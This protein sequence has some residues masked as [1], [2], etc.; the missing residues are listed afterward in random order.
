MNAA[1]E[2]AVAL[3]LLAATRQAP[4]R[5]ADDQ[6]RPAEADGK[7]SQ[8]AEIGVTLLVHGI[9][10]IPGM[11]GHVWGSPLVDGAVDPKAGLDP[12]E[13]LPSSWTGL[14]GYLERRAHRF[15]GVIR[16]LGSALDLPAC[17]DT[18]ATQGDPESATVFELEFSDGAE[19]DGLAYRAL[20]L[21][22]AVR[23]LCEFRN[24]QRV[25]LVTHSAGGLAAR[26]Y[27]QS[28]LPGLPFEHNVSRLI[29][30]STPHMGVVSA[31]TLGEMLGT[32]ATSLSV[33]ADLIRRMNQSLELPA[34]VEFAAIIVRGFAADVGGSSQAFNGYLDRAMLDALPLDYREGGDEVVQVRSQNLALTRAAR[35]YEEVNKRPVQYLLF[36]VLDPS[37]ADVTPLRQVHSASARDPRIMSMIH[38]L[39]NV[40]SPFWSD[41]PDGRVTAWR[42]EQARMAALGIIENAALGEH[43]ASEVT[44][45]DVDL[46]QQAQTGPRTDY[47]F[48]GR[49]ASRGR[50][51]KLKKHCTLV[52]GT[53]RLEFDRFGRMAACRWDVDSCQDE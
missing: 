11:S 26:A 40:R 46:Q 44:Q 43:P 47:Q 28:A 51:L 49:A 34:D 9:N 35:R 30:L 6:P 3:V 50:V 32:R 24:V 52:S 48:S 8:A 15:G 21:A 45:V 12:Q 2:I 31:D 38:E 33:N 25:C 20:E 36:R 13:T 1:R 19:I 23:A 27:L 16:P 18:S 42:D 41:Q 14:I 4:V 7:G 37:P 22:A 39:L 10:T 5:A 29:T 17:L 53:M